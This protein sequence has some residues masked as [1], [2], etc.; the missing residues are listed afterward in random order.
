MDCRRGLHAM[1]G[2]MMVFGSGVALGQP[3]PNRPIT[4]ISPYGAGGNADLA[5]RV[6]GLAVQKYLSQSLVV[7]DKPGAGGIVGSQFVIDSAKDGYTL[8]LARVGSQAVAPALDPATPYTWDGFSIIGMLEID[9]YVCVVSA[10][11]PIKSLRDLQEQLKARPGQMNYASTGNADASVVFP[12]KMFLN[13]GLKFDAATKVPYKGAADTITALLGGHVDFT[14]NGIA[15]Y[16]GGIKSGDLRALVVSTRMRVQ[17]APDAP[18]PS[19]V[20]MPDLELVS[21]WSALYGPPGLPI[22]VMAKWVSVLARLKDD[23]SWSAQVRN[24]GSV[25]EHHVAGRNA[26]FRRGPIQRLSRAR[27]TDWHRTMSK[28]VSVNP[29]I[30]RR[31]GVRFLLDYNRCPNGAGRPKAA[32]LRWDKYRGGTLLSPL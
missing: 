4:I 1:F 28:R 2:A 5:A 25:P 27:L 3:Y 10:K 13:S 11:S 30:F 26:P 19:E 20:G 15:P 21:G 9:P 17:E 29:P 6:L 8:L 18:T 7:V 12:V 23:P 22:E 31:I 32:C 14:C 24:R 16:A